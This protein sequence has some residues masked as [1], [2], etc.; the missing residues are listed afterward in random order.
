M[1]NEVN[2]EGATD[3]GIR[4]QTREPS[5]YQVHIH[6][7]DFTPMEFVIAV[8]EKFFFMDRRS[9][10][11][12]MTTAHQQGKGNCGL[13]TK[14]YAESKIV[15]VIDYARLHEHPLICSMEAVW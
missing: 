13:F 7:D 10:H 8:L 14:E 1:K 5:L 12:V 9:A 6:N 4:S 15:Q 11:E 2:K 3:L